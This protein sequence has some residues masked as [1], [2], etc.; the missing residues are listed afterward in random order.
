MKRMF[1]FIRRDNTLDTDTSVARHY[2]SAILL[3]STYFL[4]LDS[5]A[6][7]RLMHFIYRE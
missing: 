1:Y 4:S 7:V 5:L 2:F 6:G 3:G